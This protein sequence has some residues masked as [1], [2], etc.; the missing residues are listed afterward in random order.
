MKRAIGFLLSPICA[1]LLLSLLVTPQTKTDFED[2]SAFQVALQQAV[3]RL[4][5]GGKLLLA[6]TATPV[7]AKSEPVPTYDG[8]YTCETYD[9]ALA[10]CD[11]AMPG[12]LPH[13]SDPQGHTCIA[14]EYTCDLPTCE[15]YDAQMFTCDPNA[16]ACV[17]PHTTEPVPYN[18]TCDGHTCDGSFTCDFTVDPRALTCDAAD[19]QC[20]LATFNAFLPTCDP[21]R[22][23]C[24][25]NNPHGYCTAQGYNT[26]ELTTPTCDP[27]QP[28][29]D[30]VDPGK[31]G[32]ATPVKRTTWG[33]VK[34]LHEQH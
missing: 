4:E 5:G 20:E 27:G 13:T 19:P 14:G 12:C 7:A 26:C 24:R 3:D 16:A 18:H 22:I 25:E 31:P 33:Q 15:T 8:R 11:P 34:A 6:G 9:I 23:D 29:C 21:M 17:W 10:T 28:G 2:S 32:C 1:V 30:T